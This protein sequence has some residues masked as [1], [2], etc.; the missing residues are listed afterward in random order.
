MSQPILG[1]R[2]RNALANGVFLIGLA[3]LYYINW[4]WPSILLVIW[5]SVALRQWLAGH[6]FDL[7]ITSFILI[8]LFLINWL[9]IGW[10]ILMPILLVVGGIYIIGREYFAEGEDEPS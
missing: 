1:K 2:K 5:A 10:N 7:A 8:G 9:Q 4:W 3:L 6:L